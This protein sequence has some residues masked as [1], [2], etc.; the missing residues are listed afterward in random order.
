MT[1]PMAPC[2]ASR[3]MRWRNSRKRVHVPLKQVLAGVALDDDRLVEQ[4]LAALG[5]VTP[6]APALREGGGSAEQRAQ[7]LQRL[8]TQNR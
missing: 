7:H 6:D 1:R 3:P 4:Q 2:R 5:V 8:S